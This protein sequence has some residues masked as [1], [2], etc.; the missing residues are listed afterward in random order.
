MVYRQNPYLVY[1][2]IMHKIHTI[3]FRHAWEGL[4]YAFTEHPN[5]VIHSSFSVLVTIIG[6][7]FNINMFEW[8]ILISTITVGLVIELLN[9]AIE[10]TVDLI[11]DK[12]H[13]SAKH[14]KDVAAAAML[15][16]SFGAI[17]I[18]LIIFTPKIWL[19]I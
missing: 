11:T 19:Y 18:G 8:L 17:I 6:L 10:S 12:Y 7:L 1:N 5:F 4:C 13:I 3:S 9:T 16:Y 2:K 15:I 14:A